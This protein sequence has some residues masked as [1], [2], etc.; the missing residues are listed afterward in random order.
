MPPLLLQSE[1]LGLHDCACARCQADKSSQ[2]AAPEAGIQTGLSTAD[3]AELPKRHLR[4][5]LASN[6]R[7]VA[8]FRPRATCGARRLLPA[9]AALSLPASQPLD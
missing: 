8:T 9:A 5:Y 3:T 4:L 7:S 1:P 6:T 2:Q